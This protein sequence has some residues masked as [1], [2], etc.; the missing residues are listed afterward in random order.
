MRKLHGMTTRLASVRSS[1]GLDVVSSL[2]C[3]NENAIIIKYFLGLAGKFI[4][5]YFDSSV[6]LT[7]CNCDT[8]LL[9][10]VN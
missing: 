10:K 6:Q 3:Q 7:H 2:C 8:Y 1:I 5:L 4:K 9:E